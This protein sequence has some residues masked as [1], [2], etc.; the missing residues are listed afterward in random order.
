MLSQYVERIR[1]PAKVQEDIMDRKVSLQT[2]EAVCTAHS[3]AIPFENLDLVRITS[4]LGHKTKI[5]PE[6]EV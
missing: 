1:L 3:R 4:F 6:F 5:F 2:L